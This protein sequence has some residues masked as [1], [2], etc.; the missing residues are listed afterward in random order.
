MTELDEWLKPKLITYD[1]NSTQINSLISA[2]N[3]FLEPFNF[4][5]FKALLD[6]YPHPTFKDVE[7]YNKNHKNKVVLSGINY[8][9]VDDRLYEI[10]CHLERGF[11]EEVYNDS[12]KYLSMITRYENEEKK[13]THKGG[14]FYN[15]GLFLFNKGRIEE[16][17]LFIH[18]AL[19]EDH[20]KHVGTGNFPKVD[21]YKII[22]LDKTLNNPVINTAIDFISKQFLGTYTFDELYAK[23]LDIPSSIKQS[24]LKWLDHIAYFT[25]LII[26]LQRYFNI[27]E[28]LY[29]STLGELFISNILGEICL[30]IESTC[31]LKLRGLPNNATF[32]NIYK[33]LKHNHYKWNGNI[34]NKDFEET[35]LDNT[36]IDVFSNKYGGSNDPLENSFC[37]SYGLRNKVLHNINS[38]S[39]LRKKF[40]QIVRRQFEFLIDFV[41]N[42]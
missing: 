38:L 6:T 7:D 1:L 26:Q 19:K 32:L 22:T 24:E 17:L 37:L 11:K 21:S 42:K 35:N 40:K 39:I 13:H 5:S 8:A 41:I 2:L 14:V 30:L 16:A 31:K 15:I 23:F 29:F 4:D 25:K 34:S 3:T 33:N 18:R 28:D 27:T 36:L 10:I 9:G 12:F 20:M